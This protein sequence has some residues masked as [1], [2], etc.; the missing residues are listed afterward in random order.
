MATA[1]ALNNELAE[2]FILGAVLVDGNV[3][4]SMRGTLES[5]DFGIDRM[6]RIW[7]AMCA[8]YDS[9]RFVDR[10][11]VCTEMQGREPLSYLI[12]LGEGIPVVESALMTQAAALKEYR[13]RRRILALAE[14]TAKRC[15]AGDG[16]ADEIHSDLA[17]G[18]IELTAESTER[19]PIST[20]EMIDTEG[21]EALLRP[22]RSEGLRL[23]WG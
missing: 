13:L 11:T 12:E 19:R 5:E 8:I 3:M 23:Q 14:H 16:T 1:Q 6:R 21:I 18:I 2:R 7:Q 10:V 17:K 15:M 20:R 22:R 9:G 4:D